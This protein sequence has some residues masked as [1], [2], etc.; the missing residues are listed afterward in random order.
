MEFSIKSKDFTR[1]NLTLYNLIA[2][3]NFEYCYISIRNVI[4]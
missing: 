2:W 1:P 4:I 3:L